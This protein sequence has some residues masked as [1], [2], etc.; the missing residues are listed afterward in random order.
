MPK[1]SIIINNFYKRILILGGLLIIILS[2]INYYYTE[3]FINSDKTPVILVFDINNDIDIDIPVKILDNNKYPLIER[4]TIT[5]MNNKNK[6]KKIKNVS[7]F[8][9]NLKTKKFSYMSINGE[10][11]NFYSK[12]KKIFIDNEPL[13]D[14]NYGVFLY[15]SKAPKET[16]LS[17][18][19]IF[20]N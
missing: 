8:S 18:S 10:I 12:D 16:K 19:G 14:I 5:F 6:K 3:N 20:T 2:L 13:L 15:P 1:K 9:Y 7:T 17:E 11:N 4:S